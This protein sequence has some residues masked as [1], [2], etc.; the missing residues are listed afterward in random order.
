MEEQTTNASVEAADGTEATEAAEGTQEQVQETAQ[1]IDDAT[2]ET[3][4]FVY[5][6]KFKSVSELEKA[7]KELQST[8]SRKLGA[9][10]GAPEDGYTLPDD[11]PV[12]ETTAEFLQ[13]WGKENQLSQEGLETLVK[14]YYERQAQAQAEASK[15]ELEALGK[16]AKERI[17]NVKDF[18]AANLGEEYIA[19]IAPAVG[20]AKAVEAL[21]RLISMTKAPKPAETKADTLPDPDRLKAMRFAVNEKGERLMSVDPEYRRKVLEMEAKLKGEKPVY[22]IRD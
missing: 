9:F 18:L 6:D 5:A 10:K 19:A 4:E 20:S 13:E 14:N 17:Q 8:F 11:I 2:G 15:R 3:K 16:N 1:V 12:D 22:V 21:E 7:Y